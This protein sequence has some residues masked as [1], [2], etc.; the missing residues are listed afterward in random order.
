MKLMSKKAILLG[1]LALSGGPMLLAFSYFPYAEDSPKNKRVDRPII[2]RPPSRGDP[3]E[4]TSQPKIVQ[5]VALS[6]ARQGIVGQQDPTNTPRTAERTVQ[7]LLKEIPADCQKMVNTILDTSTPH[8]RNNEQRLRQYVE[9]RIDAARGVP[10]VEA[11]EIMEGYKAVED[12]C[13]AQ[14]INTYKGWALYPPEQQGR[15]R[16]SRTA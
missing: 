7:L 13:I 5:L 4:N 2:V 9:S 1:V 8:T 3:K 15:E 16:S 14:G 10:L 6:R 11:Q 12:A